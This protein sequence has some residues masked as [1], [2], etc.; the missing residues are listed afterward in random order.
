MDIKARKLSFIEQFLKI[1]NLDKLR[2]LE[3]ILNED[4]EDVWDSLPKVVQQIVSQSMEESRN[5]DVIPH[6]KV[7]EDIRAKY[8]V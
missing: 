2:K 5:G 6:H 8:K 1:S 7:M 3:L 4:T